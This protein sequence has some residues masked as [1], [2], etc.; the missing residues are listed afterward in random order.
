MPSAPRPAAPVG[1][2]V[3]PPASRH[4]EKRPWLSLTL[5]AALGAVAA[6]TLG[7]DPISDPAELAWAWGDGLSPE[8]A[9]WWLAHDGGLHL[10]ANAVG[11]ALFAPALER[12]VGPIRLAVAVLGGNL[13]GLVAHA[14]L[15]L[16][17]R[18]LLGASATV[19]AVIAY[20]LVVGWHCPFET[21]RGPLRRVWPAQVFH[22]LLAFEVVRW[23]SQV[24]A[25]R[26]PGGAA[27][28]LGGI[29][30]GVVACGLLHRRWPAGAGTRR[31][32]GAGAPAPACGREQD[33][34]PTLV[35]IGATGEGAWS[36]HR[37]PGAPRSA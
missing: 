4:T 37:Q 23:A 8:L 10:A 30:A 3:S 31:A 20:S 35:P 16:T 14:G 26:P 19:Y 18:P 32:R 24:A 12:Y 9:L 22:G 5:L 27:A 2:H 34:G 29:A 17:D 33:E 15:N 6:A 11:L 36:A 1:S 7:S 13:L 25:Q 28:H 21:R